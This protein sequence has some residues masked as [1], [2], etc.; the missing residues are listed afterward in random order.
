MLKADTMTR[1]PQGWTT[2]PPESRALLWATRHMVM[3]WP[4]C[5]SVTA[6][7]IEVLGEEAMGGEHLL[8]C[9]IVGI[10]RRA[11]RRIEFGSPACRQVLPDEELLLEAIGLDGAEPAPDALRL[12][13]G[14]G[15]APALAP[16]TAELRRVFAQAH[17]P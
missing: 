16:L 7:L 15:K 2:L 5:P 8:R 14:C 17:R 3:C 4:G 6:A 13:T 12:L 11:H 9:L 10:S 1:P